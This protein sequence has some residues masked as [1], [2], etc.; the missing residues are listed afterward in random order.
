M[1]PVTARDNDPQ[2]R[3]LHGLLAALEYTELA[4]RLAGQN[5]VSAELLLQVAR[6]HRLTPLLSAFCGPRLVAAVGEACR[7]DRLM[8]AARNLML[9]QAAEQCL[10]AFA[11]AAI[12]VIVLK[13]LAYERLY[14]AAGIRPTADVDLLVPDDRRRAAFA[15]LD[16][17]GFEPRAAAPGFDEANYHEVAWRRGNIEVDLHLALAPHVRCHIDYSDVWARAIAIPIGRSDGKALAPPHAAVFH[18][19]HMAI[20]HFDVPALYLLD[21]ARQLPS[22]AAMDAAWTTAR[23]WGCRRPFATAVALA[24]A[25]LPVW[26]ASHVSQPAP[27]F[28]ARVVSRYGPIAPLPRPEQ[29]ARK[30][31]H[32]DDPVTALR[33]VVVQARRN[34]RELVEKRIRRRSARD[35]LALDPK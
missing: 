23:A 5:D 16:R 34:A 25:F 12:P 21:L 11:D 8:T 4:D 14:G 29:L 20:D 9:A 24:E 18:A 6:R 30:L 15:T 28:A 2:R 35:R 7:R 32:F 31:L 27:W 22:H 17:L 13:G 33:Y 1:P 26:A 19:L 3:L 10:A